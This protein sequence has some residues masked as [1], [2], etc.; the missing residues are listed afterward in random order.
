VTLGE[1]T[2]TAI[3]KLDAT[4]SP[5]QIDFTFKDGL[6]EGQTV[7]GIYEVEGETYRMCRGLTAEDERPTRFA[8]PPDS[9]LRLVTYKRAPKGEGEKDKEAAIREELGRFEGSWRFDS[10]EAG[11]KKLPLNSFKGV[12]LVLKG[13]RFTQIEPGVTYGGT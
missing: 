8:A 9:G 5:R 6:Q 4:K 13:D 7:K 12:R 10:M 11:G 3:I 1:Q 2:I